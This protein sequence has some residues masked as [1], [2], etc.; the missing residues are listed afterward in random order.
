[1]LL[2]LTMVII[3]SKQF[4]NENKKTVS[5]STLKN[6]IDKERKVDFVENRLRIVLSSRLAFSKHS[7]NI[8]SVIYITEEFTSS[9]NYIDAESM[10]DG[11]DKPNNSYS[12]EKFRTFT[13]N[14]AIAERDK[15][16]KKRNSI[17]DD[18]IIQL[19]NNYLLEIVNAINIYNIIVSMILEHENLLDKD[20]IE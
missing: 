7:K 5:N 8:P 17:D 6:D 2:L 3:M 11:F 16:I 1:M 13:I 10:L 9:Y 20:I 4:T 19:I 18:T 12:I 15:M 14:E